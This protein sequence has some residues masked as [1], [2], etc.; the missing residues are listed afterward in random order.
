MLRNRRY[1]LLA[2]LVLV[3]ISLPLT[4]QLPVASA[5]TSTTTAS[6]S[7]PS[8]SSA[9]PGAT[10]VEAGSG[11]NPAFSDRAQTPGIATA[12]AV[13]GIVGAVAASPAGSRSRRKS[14]NSLTK[15]QIA[16]IAAVVIVVVGAVVAVY[17]NDTKTGSS[18]TS[19]S[20]SAP[21]AQTTTVANGTFGLSGSA[22]H[23][24]NFTIPAAR[25]NIHLSGNFNVTSG[26]TVE[27]LLMD[28]QQWSAWSAGVADNSNTQ[29]GNSSTHY[30]FYYNSTER[31]LGSIDLTFPT[32]TIG[33]TYY[34]VFI[35]PSGSQITVMTDMT[36]NWEL[37][38]PTT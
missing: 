24:Y 23:P 3:V 19:A 22:Q 16:V 5:Q 29:G 8:G 28:A 17:L 1:Y 34:L 14:S 25:Y 18:A 7:S 26:S 10:A 27:V 11:A 15:T 33:C 21:V 12:V 2:I 35:D 37:T 13:L 9:C 38:P 20:V 6:A 32:T 4:A 30:D 31:S 36:I